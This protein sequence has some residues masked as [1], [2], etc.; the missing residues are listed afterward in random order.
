[1]YVFPF[2]GHKNKGN[3]KC[4]YPTGFVTFD[5]NHLGGDSC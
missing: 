1:M 3:F 5:R 2:G 4:T